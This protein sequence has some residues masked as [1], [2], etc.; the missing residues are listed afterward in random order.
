MFEIIDKV[1]GKEIP[2]LVIVDES[3]EKRMVSKLKKENICVAYIGNGCGC[4]KGMSDEEIFEFG[5]TVGG[6]P[7]ITYDTDF[8]EFRKSG[9]N[10]ILL[11][12]NE[13]AYGNLRRL[14]KAGIVIK[15]SIT[16]KMK[17]FV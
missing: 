3:V 1:D 17:H 7:I 4:E 2:R 8:L 14:Q 15:G 16:P 10:I 13:S 9:Y 6:A 11:R 5:K 12:Q